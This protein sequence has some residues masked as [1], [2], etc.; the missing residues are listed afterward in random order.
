[1]ESQRKRTVDAVSQMR[2]RL[3]AMGI[4][5]KEKGLASSSPQRLPKGTSDSQNSLSGSLGSPS[6]NKNVT[7]IKTAISS[8][9]SAA[10]SSLTKPVSM[11]SLDVPSKDD[12]NDDE[13]DTASTVSATRDLTGF[14]L[15]SDDFD[16]DQEEIEERT[17]QCA[18]AMQ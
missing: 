12:E 13:N 11:N 14:E 1:M 3:S 15:P 10:T 9:G 5:D 17:R 18:L 2:E 6:R 8:P 4:L 7:P 16:V